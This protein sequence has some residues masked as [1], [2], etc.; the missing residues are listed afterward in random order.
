MEDVFKDSVACLRRVCFRF[1]YSLFI[2]PASGKRVR[3]FHPKYI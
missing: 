3:L 1:R 2:E